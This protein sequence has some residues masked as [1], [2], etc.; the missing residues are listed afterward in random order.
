MLLAAA[1]L[2]AIYNLWMDG[3]A[4]DASGAALKQ[5]EADISAPASGEASEKTG[6]PD[7]I[8]HPEMDMPT[9]K[10]EGQ[11]YI[12]VLK[13]PALSLELPVIS[14]WSYPN[15]K[16]APCRYQGSAYLNNMIIAAHNYSSHFGRLKNLSPGDEITFTDVDGNSFLYK[17]AAVETLSSYDIE[18]M[19]EGN[20]A[21]TLFTCTVGG[22]Y[23]VTVRCERAED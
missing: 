20:W 12:G 21:L 1:L 4:G 3:R 2:L 5:L 14:E 16:I 19:T 7:Y 15:L 10:I 23:R 6:V 17:V 11:Y 22:E 8:L 13:I 18:D 9:E